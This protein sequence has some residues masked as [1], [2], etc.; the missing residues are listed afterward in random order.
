[1]RLPR[2]VFGVPGR[3]RRARPAQPARRRGL[4]EGLGHRHLRHRRDVDRGAHRLGRPGV[5]RPD[6]VR[7]RRGG[8]RRQG[9]L[10]VGLRPRA[11]PPA[12]RGGRAPSWPSSSGC[13]PCGCGASTSPSPRSPSRWPPRPTS[14]TRSSSSGCPTRTTASSGPPSS[15]A[16]TTTR[17]PASTTCPW[18]CSPWWCG[19]CWASGAAAPA[20]CCSALREN[21][22]AAQSYGVSV[23]PGQ[24]HRLRPVRLRRRRGRGAARPPPAEPQHETLYGTRPRASP[25]SSPPWSAASGSVPGAVLGALFLQGAQWFLPAE[26][27]GAGLGRRRAARAAGPARRSRRR[28]STGSATCCCARVGRPAGHRGAEPGGRRGRGG[29]PP[30]APRSDRRGAWTAR[31]HRW[32]TAARRP[33]GRAARSDRRDRAPPRPVGGDR[34]APTGPRGPVAAVLARVPPPG[35][36]PCGPHRAARSTPLIILF[37][38]NAVDELDRTAFGILLP[39]IQDDFGLDLTG[40]PRRSSPWCRPRPCC[41]RCPSR[42]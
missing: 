7:R 1:M 2:V 12:R 38:L 42:R 14:S 4:A 10:A 26:L 35:R 36:W 13:R 8:G 18:R 29:A 34:D 31:R 6:V 41:S 21:E 28:S 9:H 11:R 19:W 20:G 27:A 22:R 33:P 17:R 40:D 30:S 16:S 23:D 3:A 37:G 32:P 25:S 5:A 24:A 39:D 15:A